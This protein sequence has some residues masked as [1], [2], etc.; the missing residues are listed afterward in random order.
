[1][2]TITIL[3]QTP[4][5]KNSKQIV[6]NR[7]TGKT[8]LISSN[9]VQAWKKIAA[10]QLNQYKD[11]FD[12]KIQIDYLFY[13]KDNRRRDTD[14]M[15]ASVNDSLMASGIIKDDCWQLL[16]IGSADAQID[17]ENPRCEII[18]TKL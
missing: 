16:R 6:H 2:A 3:G 15:I 12:S 4:S 14:N 8:M 7:Y 17:K 13:V 11:R 1:M 5:Q 10:Y 18:I 9:I